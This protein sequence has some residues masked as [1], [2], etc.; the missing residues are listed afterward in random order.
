MRVLWLRVGGGEEKGPPPPR[1][2][3]STACVERIGLRG[4]RTFVPQEHLVGL[5]SMRR[6]R[7]GSLYMTYFAVL[8]ECPN[9]KQPN[10]P[11]SSESNGWCDPCIDDVLG[12]QATEALL[13]MEPKQVFER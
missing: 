11:S 4:E 6:G 3:P 10:L 2:H 13:N 8:T 12:E 9:C 7:K 5:R 1:A